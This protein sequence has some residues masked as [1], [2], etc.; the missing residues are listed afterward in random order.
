MLGTAARAF[1]ME[2]DHVFPAATAQVAQLSILS[3]TDTAVFG[4]LIAAYQARHPGVAVRYTV[5]S[6]QQIYLAVTAAAAPGYDVVISSA[7]DLQMK[8]AN[9]GYAR[10]H[11]LPPGVALPGWAQWQD[12][13]FAFAQEPVVVLLSRAALKGLAL[14]HTR[15]D[16]IALLR[17]DP[18]RFRGRVGTYD[19]RASGTGYLF[20][21]QEAR[22]S[23]SFWRLAEVMGTLAPR[24]YT[25]S[26]DMIADLK[27]G[28][29]VLATNVIG[30]YAAPQFPPGS[31]GQ[32]VE[33]QDLTLTLLRTA[34]IPRTAQRPDLGGGF[35]DFLL[36][37]EGYRLIL[38]SGLP[39]IGG[40]AFS[41]APHLRPIRLDPGLLVYLDRL[42]RQ[43]FLEEWTAALVRH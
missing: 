31:D 2:E 12:R 22:Q 5:A 40:A 23:D 27:S 7:M 26:A 9:D 24:L 30:S 33:L 18:D 38:A 41:D 20:A 19:V 10:A 4:P 25:S 16:L 29:L 43:N 15:R 42:K 32:I 34:F 17:D 28:A 6:S 1:D 11:A 13:L 14:P 8:L 37:P 36:G 35:I 21:T 3:T 39:P